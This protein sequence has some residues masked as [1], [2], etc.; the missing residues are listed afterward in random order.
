RIPTNASDLARYGG[1]TNYNEDRGMLSFGMTRF[2]TL[3]LYSI[4]AG[5]FRIPV[6]L[7]DSSPTKTTPTRKPSAAP[8]DFERQ[9][10]GLFGRLGCNAGSCHG[11]FQ[12]RGGFRISLFGYDADMDYNAITHDALGRRINCVDPDKSLILLKPTAQIEH[13]GGKRF[14]KASWQY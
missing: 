3:F 2:R 14:D 13:G 1:S 4:V 6:G 9:V 10:V 5:L 7:A 8:V 11:S 12:G